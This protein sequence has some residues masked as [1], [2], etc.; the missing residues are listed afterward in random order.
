MRRF[1]PRN[2]GGHQRPHVRAPGV[3]VGLITTAGFE[4]SLPTAK[5]RRVNDGVWSVYPEPIVPRDRIIGVPERI[6]RDGHV[7]MPLDP[8]AAVAAAQRLIDELDCESIAMSFLW[9][10]RNPVHELAAAEAIRDAFP[11]CRSSPARNARRRSANSSERR[12][13]C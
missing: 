10:F 4:D 9:S 5:G 8:A 7:L 3:R 6:D 11:G 12:T 13:R 2:D 1:G